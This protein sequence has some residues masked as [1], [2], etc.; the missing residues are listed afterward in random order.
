MVGE[1]VNK[2][3]NGPISKA[4]DISEDLM[5]YLDKVMTGI[6]DS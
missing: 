6:I 3:L 4:Q 2:E 1:D 5:P